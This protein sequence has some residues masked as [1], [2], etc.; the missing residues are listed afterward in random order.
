MSSADPYVKDGVLLNR[1]GITDPQT[2][3]RAEADLASPRLL[4]QERDLGRDR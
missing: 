3:Q 1:L 2:L 4:Q